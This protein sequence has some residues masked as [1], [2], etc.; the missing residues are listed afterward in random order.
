MPNREP[1]TLLETLSLITLA[2][3]ILIFVIQFL[4]RFAPRGTYSAIERIEQK[5][6][7]CQP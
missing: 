3:V 6:N 7:Q 4:E 2:M 5:V 1:A